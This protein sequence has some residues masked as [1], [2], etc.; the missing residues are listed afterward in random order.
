VRGDARV[1]TF[2]V[3]NFERFQH[4]KDRS[5]PWIKLY[6]ELLDDYAFTCLQDA[7]KFHLIAIW[8]LASRTDNKIPADPA[9]IARKISASSKVDLAGLIEAGFLVEN[10]PLL[11]MEQDASAPLA[12]CLSREEER[13]GETEERESAQ[14]EEF[15]NAYPRKIAKPDAKRAFKAAIKK[16]SL[17]VLLAAIGSIDKSDPKFIPYPATWLNQERWAD[18]ALK[19]NGGSG[20]A[21]AGDDLWRWRVEGY[22]KRKFWKPDWGALSGAECQVPPAILKEFGLS[23]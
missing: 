17:P 20:P 6:N 8:L 14:F 11:E 12:K 10:Q 23:A 18:A 7:S 5:P 22:V 15:W 4:Y 16:T 13:R 21:L 2:S 19:T 9:W 3:K 1:K